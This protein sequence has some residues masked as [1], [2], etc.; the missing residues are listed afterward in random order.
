MKITKEERNYMFR[1]LE[2]A[3]RF[4]D[5]VSDEMGSLYGYAGPG[6]LRSDEDKALYEGISKKIIKYEYDRHK[7]NID[8]FIK[9]WRKKKENDVVVEDVPYNLKFQEK[10]AELHGKRT[11]FPDDAVMEKMMEKQYT[12]ADKT[13]VIK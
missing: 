3:D 11:M 6:V 8:E 12:L 13:R 9:D 5:P 4:L 7:G 10:L 1:F 2:Q